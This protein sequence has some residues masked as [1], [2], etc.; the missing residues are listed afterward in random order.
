MGVSALPPAL[1]SGDG[2]HPFLARI[3]AKAT[4]RF[5]WTSAAALRHATSAAYWCHVF[6]RD[7]EALEICTFLARYDFAGNYALWTPVESA[8]A[9]RAR[10]LRSGRNAAEAG[11]C[12]QRIRDAGFVCD[13]LEGA[14]L[15]RNSALKV[16][17]ERHSRA[18]ERDARLLRL[19]ELCFIIELGGSRTL[20]VQEAEADYQRNLARLRELAG[21]D[22]PTRSGAGEVV[23]RQ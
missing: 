17:L 10:L 18:A 11:G 5:R 9:L 4:K 20:P 19:R 3:K 14:L 23:S 12:V 21:A 13:R 22:G 8:L 1:L 2:S 16:A 6:R 15:D 7:D